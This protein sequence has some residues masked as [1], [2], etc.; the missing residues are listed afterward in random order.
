MAS[1]NDAENGIGLQ[2]RIASLEQ[3]LR[4]YTLL[5]V[6]PY[7]RSYSWTQAEVSRLIQDVRAAVARDARYYFV[8]LLVLVSTNPDEAEIVDGLQR[9][10]TLSMV[11]AYVRD[12]LGPE[13]A[14]DLGAL[15]APVPRTEQSAARGLH[16]R[17]VDA[18]FFAE[19]VQTPGAMLALAGLTGCENETHALLV[20]AAKAI[21]EGLED[22]DGAAL[23]A[24]RLAL[25][26][27]VVFSVM[28]T[29]DRDGASLLFRVLNDRGQ[30][31]SDAAMI[32]SE[33]LTQGSLSE[34]EA[35]TFA[36]AWDGLEQRLG[37]S[38]FETLLDIMP[39]IISGKGGESRGDLA[40]F[41]R[42]VLGQIEA[43]RILAEDLPRYAHALEA[44]DRRAIDAGAHTAQVRRRLI[45]LSWLRDRYW[46]A[47][48]VAFLA[49][50]AG[51]AASET[52][53]ALALNFFERL[54]RLAFATFFGVIKSDRRQER[55]AQVVRARGRPEALFGAKG[56]LELT[57][58]ERRDLIQRLNAPFQSQGKAK[59]RRIVA[60]RVEAALGQAFEMSSQFTLE[61]ILPIRPSGLW[62]RAFP[63]AEQ[64]EALTHLIGNWA[65]VTE[66]ENQI[67][68]DKSY[69]DKMSIFLRENKK[70]PVRPLTEDLKEISEWT[71]IV[72]KLRH[73]RLVARLCADWDLL[74]RSER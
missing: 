57:E 47:P 55:F 31:P 6:P 27:R 59:E 41:R 63:L 61:H 39:L 25:L 50:H 15:L 64:R 28:R 16:L 62:L 71:P 19:H 20:E 38:R 8:G 43:K 66:P 69:K 37:R 51:D 5:T 35:A 70:E 53:N 68:A 52:A 74:R 1:H 44:I 40:V 33:L 73:E 60:W 58:A 72:I 42:D 21:V 2:S 10:T 65:I 32:K 12:R 3:V 36:D 34:G 13:E 22:M 49:D 23:R 45:C 11:L 29:E 4:T 17:R 18:A 54:E 14:A 24:L 56:A 30:D 26:G 7:Q 48:A 46:L 67:A 9:L